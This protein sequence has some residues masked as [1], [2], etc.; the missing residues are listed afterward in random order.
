[1]ES[2]G[3]RVVLDSL[4]INLTCNAIEWG[5]SN[6]CKEWNYVMTFAIGT[7]SAY[8]IRISEFRMNYKL[9]RKQTR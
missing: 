9:P 4:F 2:G 5:I 6:H 3:L 7:V 8:L 1:M